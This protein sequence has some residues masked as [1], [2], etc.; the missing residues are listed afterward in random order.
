[1][2]E[3]NM[4]V[5]LGIDFGTSYTFIVKKNSA[6]N[7]EVINESLY[8]NFFG[9][10]KP[11]TA[12]SGIRTVIGYG[13]KNCSGD[14]K[15]VIGIEVDAEICDK[16]I[17]RGLKTKIRNVFK[18]R[19]RTYAVNHGMQYVASIEDIPTDEHFGCYFY[20]S[21][22]S[23]F[24][25]DAI[26]LAKAFFYRALQEDDNYTTIQDVDRII[27]GVPAD[28]L[29][30]ENGI[31]SHD[32]NNCV[33]TK[34]FEEVKKVINKEVEVKIGSEPV[35]AANAYVKN[36][37]DWS[38][39]GDYILVVDIG[40][41]T[42][43]FALIKRIEDGYIQAVASKGGTNPAGEDFDMTLRELLQESTG[44][45][46]NENAIIATKERLFMPFSK[47][48]LSNWLVGAEAEDGYNDYCQSGRR[49]KIR[50]KN[51]QEYT[52]SFDANHDGG[53]PNCIHYVS[54]FQDQCNKLIKRIVSYVND[55]TNNLKGQR[56]L[57][58][59]SIPISSLMFVGGT[60]NMDL[61]REAIILGLGINQ[62]IVTKE[63]TYNGTPIDYLFW[64]T[65]DSSEIKL[66]GSNMIAIGAAFHGEPIFSNSTNSRKNNIL[67]NSKTSREIAMS[68]SDIY[69]MVKS[70][71]DY[72]EYLILSQ[73]L[74]NNG[75]DERIDNENW[76][77]VFNCAENES[78]LEFKIKV[79]LS[80]DKYIIYPT[81]KKNYSIGLP[82]NKAIDVVFFADSS[83]REL[84]LFGCL[85]DKEI[86]ARMY[87]V[88]SYDFKCL[89]TNE[90]IVIN[91]VEGVRANRKNFRLYPI[92]NPSEEEL[93]GVPVM[94]EKKEVTGRM[95][96]TKS[97]RYYSIIT[98]KLDFGWE[99]IKKES[100]N[101]R[102]K[103][104][105]N[106]L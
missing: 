25:M 27:V 65:R 56:L 92:K 12:S 26:T 85:I 68:I 101:A 103:T 21:D 34:I 5:T 43:D 4:A 86:K 36:H 3:N 93:E 9:G 30:R 42:A 29:D 73:Y 67:E 50:D 2:E 105:N 17:C 38:N 70:G 60:C 83:C 95:K 28:E 35:L 100:E 64:E 66:T 39:V 54:K 13:G 89:E 47:Y 72:D 71:S 84:V 24:F 37:P 52:V 75:N 99:I 69:I 11:L 77:L 16:N 45:E 1:M 62:D 31:S 8:E 49:I 80:E 51:N 46:F 33:V 48:K 102:K 18:C 10:Y 76:P 44:S 58:G 88:K 63:Y 74:K 23:R 104:I 20:E 78:K 22:G 55:A 7:I 106:K 82:Q 59:N 94:E 91:E 81:G 32:Y 61:L 41:G 57:E 97:A 96:K 90:S 87:K 79:G 53:T 14:R 6:G 19:N 98:N 40:G 15:W